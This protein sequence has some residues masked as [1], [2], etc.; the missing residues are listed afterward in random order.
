M[1]I[2]ITGAILDVMLHMSA[3]WPTNNDDVCICEKSYL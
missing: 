1:Y 3:S 2:G